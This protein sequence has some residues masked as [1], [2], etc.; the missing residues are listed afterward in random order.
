MNAAVRRPRVVNLCLAALAV[1]VGIP[2]AMM[3][4]TPP[5]LDWLPDQ[6]HGEITPAVLA[7]YPVGSTGDWVAADL[8][9]KGFLPAQPYTGFRRAF[10]RVHGGF[11]CSRSWEIMWRERTD[12]TVAAL[13]GYARETCL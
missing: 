1:V 3:V 2:L 4:Y 7:R 13:A 6:W 10:A 8:A 11:A 5:G 12:G 9:A